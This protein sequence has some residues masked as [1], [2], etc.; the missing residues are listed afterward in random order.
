[1]YQFTSPEKLDT[2]VPEHFDGFDCGCPQVNKYVLNAERM[3]KE[4]ESRNI[5]FY[6]IYEQRDLTK[7]VGFF[8]LKNSNIENKEFTDSQKKRDIQRLPHAGA[9]E[10]VYLGVSKEYAKIGLGS[11]LL[12]KAEEIYANMDLPGMIF[13]LISSPSANDF[14]EKNEYIKMKPTT[15]MVLNEDG[16]KVEIML[17]RYFKPLKQIMH[18]LAVVAQSSPAVES[19]MAT[20]VV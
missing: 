13:Y 18:D 5:N 8:S 14:Y 1:M 6:V 17:N 20:Q 2:F 19:D 11:A 9:V 10:L 7:V 3:Q 16:E 15:T 12:S 4:I